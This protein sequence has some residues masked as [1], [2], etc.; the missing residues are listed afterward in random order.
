MSV[1]TTSSRLSARIGKDCYEQLCQIY[2]I[3]APGTGLVKIGYAVDVLERFN[4]MLTMS[5]VPLSLLASMPGGP[6]MEAELHVRF[7]NSRTH[8]EWFIRTSDLDPIIAGAATQYDPKFFHH[9]LAGYR[10]AALQDYMEKVRRGEV[11][12]PTRGPTRPS[13][14]KTHDRYGNSIERK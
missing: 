7:A 9:R 4:G 11:V 5:P 13:K 12:R 14:R 2:F 3:E 8:G 6:Q 1:P 10:G